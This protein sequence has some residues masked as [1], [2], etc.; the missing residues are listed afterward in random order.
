MIN[1]HVQ[2]M[3]HLGANPES[4]ILPSGKT[5]TKFS[6]ATNAYAKDTAGEFKTITHWHPIV[7]WGEL[8]ER[9]VKNLQKGSKV[10]INGSLEQKSWKNDEGRT[11][12]RT[13][14]LARRFSLLS[15][16]KE[17]DVETED[18]VAPF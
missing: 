9:M 7:A 1:N 11:Q 18:M 10:I 15:G 13:E 4:L 2:L 8:A 17:A 6:I 3:G 12:R 5:L 16:K 14:V